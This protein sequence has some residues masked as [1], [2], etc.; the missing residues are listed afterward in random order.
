MQEGF[1]SFYI[2]LNVAVDSESVYEL[3]Y[4]TM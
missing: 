2:L 3:Y 1:S 4:N